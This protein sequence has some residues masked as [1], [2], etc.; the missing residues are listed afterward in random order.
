M[1]LDPMPPDGRDL[2]LSVGKDERALV[3][4]RLGVTEIHNLD[5]SLHAVRF[6]GGIRVTGRLTA[7]IVQ[8]SVV[9]F[10][11]VRQEIDEPI[12]RVFLPSGERPRAGS[13]AAEIFVDPDAEDAPDYFEGP[14]VDFSELIVET[15]SLAID[16]Y[17]RGEGEGLDALGLPQQDE[18][19][20][21]FASLESLKKRL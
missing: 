9:T 20:S 18:D 14:E 12:D 21:P 15:L 11:P 3:A 1:R 16:P 8:P 10:D 5:V 19:E 4:D 17:P 7:V 13:A 6:R 2:A